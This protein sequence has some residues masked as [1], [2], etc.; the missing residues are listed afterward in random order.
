M[1]L[2]F[3]MVYD[4]GHLRLTDFGLS[5]RLKQGGRAFTI[6]GTIQYMGTHTQVIN[7][8]SEV[9]LFMALPK[10]CFIDSP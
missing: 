3:S 10:T 6:C 9:I 4:S 8:C 5:R 1:S 2:N 7:N